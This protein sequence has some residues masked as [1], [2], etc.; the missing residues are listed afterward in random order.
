M[1]LVMA[2]VILATTWL[3]DPPDVD[4]LWFDRFY[5]QFLAMWTDDDVSSALEIA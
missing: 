4:R 1:V 3:R 5:S 2:S